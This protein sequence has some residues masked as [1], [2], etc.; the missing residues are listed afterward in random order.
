MCQLI[1]NLLPRRSPVSIKKYTC[2][3]H[4]V[5]HTHKNKLNA[6]KIN[7]SVSDAGCQAV[8]FINR[9]SR[10]T[11]LHRVNVSLLAG[12]FQVV[13]VRLLMWIIIMWLINKC[14]R[15]FTKGVKNSF[16]GQ[17]MPH[18]KPLLAAF[19]PTSLLCAV[20]RCYN[21]FSTRVSLSRF[22]WATGQLFIFQLGTY[23]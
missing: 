22:H 15:H 6:T 17:H 5:T 18:S 14:W 7:G 2:S 4:V 16:G 19:H 10:L 3:N 8:L 11:D 23:M 12:S 1:P 9:F 20:F 13:E 21:L